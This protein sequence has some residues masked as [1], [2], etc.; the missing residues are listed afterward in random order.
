MECEKIRFYP[1]KNEQNITVYQT[2]CS[3]NFQPPLADSKLMVLK[4]PEQEMKLMFPQSNNLQTKR[5][6][7]EKKRLILICDHTQT[8]NVFWRT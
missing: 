2:S 3:R 8:F 4:Q 7:G 1:S 6:R 5:Q